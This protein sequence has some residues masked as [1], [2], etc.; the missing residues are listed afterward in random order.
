MN[1][2]VI[3]RLAGL[4][5]SVI[6]L[7]CFTACEHKVTSTVTAAK[8]ENDII[9]T[10][11]FPAMVSLNEE[12]LANHFSFPAESISDFRV[13]ISETED[14]SDE[15]AIFIISD[16]VSNADVMNV[17]STH[18]TN[19]ASSFKKISEIEYN[20][21]QNAVIRRFNVVDGL[22]VAVIISDTPELAA[23]ILE[24]M[25]GELA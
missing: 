20:K 21:L 23:K 3:Y 16:K 5:A 25:G 8:I 22:L 24:D 10:I 2:S 11:K 13:M 6:L 1:C 17:I 14:R 4:L 7:L 15:I 12:Q 18:I 19:R 9:A